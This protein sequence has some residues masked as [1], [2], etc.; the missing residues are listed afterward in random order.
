MKRGLRLKTYDTSTDGSVGL[1]RREVASWLGLLL[2]TFNILAGGTLPARAEGSA[3]APFAQAL[4]GD[5]IVVCTASGMVVMDRD[6]HVVDPGTTGGGHAE[7][8]VFCLPLMHGGVQ[9]PTLSAAIVDI[10][11]PVVPVGEFTAVDQS[12]AK[13]VRL[14]GAS[15]PRAPPFS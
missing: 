12:V 8:C 13:P 6:G 7:L 9:A 5:R 4:L 2:L 3:P 11:A 10:F 1:L 14:T 15:S